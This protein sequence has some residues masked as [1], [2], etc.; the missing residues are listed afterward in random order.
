MSVNLVSVG[1]KDVTKMKANSFFC[2]GVTLAH[3]VISVCLHSYATPRR[4]VFSSLFSIQTPMHY[5]C[6]LKLSLSISPVL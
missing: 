4:V 5:F 6:S 2:H 3:R 1:T